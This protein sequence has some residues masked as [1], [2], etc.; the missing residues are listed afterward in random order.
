M[1]HLLPKDEVLGLF[2]KSL[3]VFKKAQED[4]AHF[5]FRNYNLDYYQNRFTCSKNITLLKLSSAAA[6]YSPSV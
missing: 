6:L 3:A 1:C 4:Y 2:L 5:Q